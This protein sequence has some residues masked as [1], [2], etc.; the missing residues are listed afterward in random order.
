MRR[1]AASAAVA[2][3]ACVYPGAAGAIVYGAPDGDAHPAVGVVRFWDGSGKYIQRCSGTMLSPRVLLTAAHCTAGASTARVWLSSTAPTIR[4]VEAGAGD[5]GYAG[6]PYTHP[7]W[8]GLFP[9]DTHDVG[10]VVLST[11][12]VGLSTFGELPAVGE[13]DD[14]AL[15]RG[16]KDQLFT[17]VGYGLQ[18]TKPGYVELVARFAGTARLV[19]AS[20][21]PTDGYN[22]RLSSDP[23]APHSGGICLGDSGGPAFYGGSNVIAGVSSF[24]RKEDC[25]GGGFVHRLDLAG[26]NAWVGSFL[27]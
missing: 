26:E 7:G 5:P 15:R 9:P 1:F 24:L 18:G 27:G 2:L 11:A 23:G 12:A 22:F 20:S 21:A 14:L 16:Q 13:F 25:F 8:R 6:T 17:L 10:V 4:E 19:T 3:F